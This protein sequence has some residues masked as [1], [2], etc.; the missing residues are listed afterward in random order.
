MPLW[1]AEN[2]GWMPGCGSCD[3]VAR[4]AH[5]L[6]LGFA[7]AVL[8]GFLFTK[9][10]APKLTLAVGLWLLAR[11]A[12]WLPLPAPFGLLALGYP[13]CLF[14]LGGWPFLKA[15]R[16]GHNRV[17]APAIAAFA[18]AEALFQAGRLGLLAGG[19][20]QGA[21]MAFDLVALMILVM[22][23]RV[24]PAAMAGLVRKEES[25]DLFDRNGPRLE[26]AA[27]AGMA[28]A[29]LCHG[30]GWGDGASA[31]LALAGLAALLRQRRWRLKV[32]L[33]DASMGPVQV[34]YAL[35][36]AGLVLAAVADWSGIGPTSDALHLA[37]IG[38]MGMVVAAMM[39]RIN[40]IRERIPG[41]M[42][43]AAI[44]IAALL[45]LAADLRVMAPLEPAWL[46]PAS[47]LLW[48]LAF[49]AV[50]AVLVG[51]WTTRHP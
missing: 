46:I 17:F 25:R 6:L 43:Q 9:V 29:A 13:L 23:G 39:L 4:H 41:P 28:V 44:P 15:A 5:E 51:T 49:L 22:G 24:I 2:A 37:T 11:L 27:V 36:A 38:G 31:G 8:G 1:V 20:R 12:V 47:A 48:S 32:A 30:L 7:A 19:E 18:A 14:W 35:L 40:H 33:G 50:A 45:A 10:S 21:L 26:L 16:T 34:G 3:P 42:P